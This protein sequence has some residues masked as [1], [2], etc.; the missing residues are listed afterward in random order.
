MALKGAAKMARA[1]AQAA[2]PVLNRASVREQLQTECW[3]YIEV[4]PN[5]WGKGFTREQA[6]EA[7]GKP[8]HY[9]VYATS[10]PWASIDEM[11]AICYTP[12][13]TADAPDLRIP[14]WVEVTRTAP[15]RAAKGGAR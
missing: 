1:K 14:V 9:I 15:P 7:A 11:G 3:I 13:E 12:R 6:H 10:D 8:K 4:G 2:A 5:V